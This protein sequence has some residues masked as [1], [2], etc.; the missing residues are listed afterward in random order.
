MGF[1]DSID[2]FLTGVS[3][4]LSLPKFSYLVRMKEGREKLQNV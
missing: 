2:D 4:A 1:F 3:I